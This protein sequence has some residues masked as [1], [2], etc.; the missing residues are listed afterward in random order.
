VGTAPAY[1][2]PRQAVSGPRQGA[3]VCARVWDLASVWGRARVW[4]LA[5]ARFATLEAW[6]PGRLG[7]VPESATASRRN[8]TRTLVI[9]RCPWRLV[10][11]G[12]DIPKQSVLE[13]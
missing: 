7:E 2:D 11:S 6:D 12:S 9:E 5:G 8:T 3:A 10:A 1:G 13:V 4:D